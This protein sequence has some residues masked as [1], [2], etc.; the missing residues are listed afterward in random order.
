MRIIKNAI[1]CNICGDEIES[2][3]VHNFVTCKCGASSVDGGQEYLRRV[4]KEEGCFT[5]L[6][7]FEAEAEKEDGTY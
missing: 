2:K 6:S 5:E 3:H 7:V 4:Y 1:C